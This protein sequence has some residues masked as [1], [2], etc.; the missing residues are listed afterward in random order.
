MLQVEDDAVNPLRTFGDNL[1]RHGN[2]RR[3]LVA[4]SPAKAIEPRWASGADLVGDSVQGDHAGARKMLG[5]NLKAAP[6]IGMRMRENDAIDRLA[7]RLH[8]GRNPGGIW[9]QELTIEDDDRIWPLNHLRIDLKAVG[10]AEVG[11]NFDGSELADEDGPQAAWRRR[12]LG[13]RCAAVLRQLRVRRGSTR[14]APADGR[15]QR[16]R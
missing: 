9:Q 3:S 15:K 12:I 2:L 16:A 10:G 4:I 11:V 8:V 6:V 13:P 14:Q 7:E 5:Q 1:R